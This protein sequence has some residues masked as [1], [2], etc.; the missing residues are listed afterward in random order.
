[1]ERLNYC[2]AIRKQYLDWIQRPSLRGEP[3]GGVRHI[4]DLCE[5]SQKFALPAGGVFLMDP[6]WRALDDSE[7][8]KLPYQFVALEYA[9]PN[10]F[11]TRRVVFLREVDGQIMGD[12]VA[13]MDHNGT[14]APSSRFGIPTTGYM[15]RNQVNGDG[16]PAILAWSES[17]DGTG[18]RDRELFVPLYF[19]NALSCTNVHVERDEP[20]KAGRKI[21]AALAFDTYHVLTIDVP[22][23]AGAAGG[24][25]GAHR[26]PREHL[27]RGHIRRLADG[28]RVWVN[29][30]VV[31]AGRGAGVVTKDYALRA[32]A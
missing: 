21:K 2:R 1:M 29:A 27:R 22:G 31:A 32:A 8:L 13:W 25:C 23:R 5:A 26:S 19:L 10:T 24:I 16:G 17:L 6:E 9:V 12:C 14:W 7:P 4:I 20:K 11:P 28:R 3:M 18:F 15:D 30:T